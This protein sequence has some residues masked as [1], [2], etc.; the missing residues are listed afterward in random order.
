MDTNNLW[1]IPYIDEP[2]SFWEKLKE[3]HGEHIDEVYLP[4]PMPNLPTGR[5]LQPEHFVLDFLKHTPFK[6]SFLINPI[7]FNKPIEELSPRII[8]SL[9]RLYDKYNIQSVTIS[10][11]TL[12]TEIKKNIQNIKLH[13]SVLMD[14]FEPA[15]L[16]YINDVFDVLVPS[17][18][19]IRNLKALRVLKNGF[20]GQVKLIVNEGCLPHC[21]Y[22]VQHFFEMGNKTDYPKSLCNSILEE[23]PWL[24]LTGSWILPQHIGMYDGLFDKLKLSGRVTL[25]NPA[26]YNDVL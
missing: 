6:L 9:K 23:K 12:A 17:S 8:E 11:L 21:I 5:P 24:R 25:Q 20:K 3:V 1:T 19:I 14:I 26:Y 7:V 13:T 15:Q 16:N 18:R 22:R 2:I 4:L 10:N